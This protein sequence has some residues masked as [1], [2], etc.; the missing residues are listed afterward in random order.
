[1]RRAEQPT[2]S[3]T[4]GQ[5]PLEATAARIDLIVLGAHGRAGLDHF[6]LGSVAETIVRGAPC[7]VLTVRAQNG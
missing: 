1:L 7:P 3:S 6:L 5:I 2:V 4:R